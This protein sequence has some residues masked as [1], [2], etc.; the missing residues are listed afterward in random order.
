M[1]HGLKE[2]QRRSRR[3]ALD[4]PL[5]S[6]S[7]TTAWRRVVTVMKQADITAGPHRV[8]KGLRHGYAIHALNKG[9]S[10]HLLSKWMATPSWKLT[11]SMPMLWAKNSKPLPPTCGHELAGTSKV[12]GGVAIVRWQ[13][14][15]LA[16]GVALC[17]RSATSWLFLRLRESPLVSRERIRFVLW[18]CCRIL[19]VSTRQ[20]I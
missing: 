7:R 17:L 8:P 2:I 3:H 4:Q 9:V 18:N 14:D 15:G 6:W 1:V 5:W 19:W 16:Y 20:G 13:T 10:L 11:P 12:I